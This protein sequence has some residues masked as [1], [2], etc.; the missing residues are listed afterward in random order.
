MSDSDEDYVEYGTPLDPLDEDAVPKK[1]PF[2]LE[3][4]VA[5]NSK[6]R[7][8]GAFTGGFSAGFF[9]T[10]GSLEGWT[11]STFKSSR[12]DKAERKIQKPEDFM[13][14]EDVGEFG[15]APKVL[16]STSDYADH[17]NARKRE[18][19]G[20][21]TGPIPGEP[22]LKQ[23]LQPARDTIGIKLL[24]RMGWKPG[25]GV[26]PRLTKKEKKQSRKEHLKMTKKVYGCAP[27]E[28]TDGYNSSGNSS[29]SSDEED[30]NITFAPDDYEPFLCKPKDNCFGIGYSG[31]DRRSVLSSHINLFQPSSLI[32]N[33]K[34]KKVSISGQAFGVGA[35]EE[36]DED[37]YALEDMSQYDF[38]LG[39]NDSLKL[40]KKKDSVK[41]DNNKED[42][43]DGFVC[44][45]HSVS[46]RK[47]FPPPELP[48][49][50]QPFHTVRKTRFESAPDESQ[51]NNFRK[52]GLQRHALSSNDRAQILNDN[53][54]CMHMTASEESEMDENKMLAKEAAKITEKL[55]ENSVATKFCPFAGRPDKQ[56]R[57]EQYTALVKAGRKADFAKCQPLDMT[58]WQREQEVAEFER[59]AKLEA[60]MNDRFVPASAPGADVLQEEIPACVSAAKAK[61]FGKLT[62]ERSVWK[63]TSLLCKRFNVPEPQAGI[64]QPS[65]SL[66]R[67][68]GVSKFSVF[69]FLDAANH[70]IKLTEAQV[71]D[72]AETAKTSAVSPVQKKG[73]VP[74]TQSTTSS[75]V[76]D[77]DLTDQTNDDRV[78]DFAD[79][80]S[81]M[82]LYKAVFLSSSEDESASEDERTN[83]NKSPSQSA[84]TQH[85]KLEPGIT[86]AAEEVPGTSSFGRS[87][88]AATEP[89]KQTPASALNILRNTSPPRGIFSNLDLDAINTQ[90]KE[91]MQGKSCDF[92]LGLS[93]TD[94]DPVRS[95]EDTV[96]ADA[97]SGAKT[98]TGGSKPAQAQVDDNSAAMESGMYGPSLPSTP[99]P[100][101]TKNTKLISES[102]L[103]DELSSFI[104]VEKKNKTSRREKHKKEHKKAS[105]HK[106]HK[107][108]KHKKSKH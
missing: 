30:E 5:R 27:P 42:T 21:A 8:H 97:I 25:Q 44:A 3:E 95:S 41:R 12:S 101:V 96:N 18:R 60:A 76:A 39:G 67:K 102:N 1:K 47:F 13:D 91:G 40:Q 77:K 10:V 2:R 71:T 28:S 74:Q 58:E 79:P 24:K 35:L 11:P 57:Y 48:P 75:T 26:G 33:E 6:Q 53:N 107:S 52:M 36:E 100:H 78:M 86:R 45:T 62:R 66:V 104:W 92:N 87:S 81:K 9:N 72:E 103:T 83:T 20:P 88:F 69:D 93:R 65:A 37:I 70:N 19:V 15:I 4:I 51:E 49:N 31:L 22:V 94:S 98:T 55:S 106:K 34:N 82:D 59:V 63:P 99:I 46:S 54:T 85:I 23:L 68:K 14:D 50:F 7:F 108:K 43:L 73:T 84:I 38:S 80:P 61:M 64:S 90:I 17:L 105:K 16:R 89:L 32:M 29:E 56:S